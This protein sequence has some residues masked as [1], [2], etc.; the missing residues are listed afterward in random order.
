M[1]TDLRLKQYEGLAES[2]HLR[3]LSLGI[4]NGEPWFM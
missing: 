1:I 2:T 3:V 4:N